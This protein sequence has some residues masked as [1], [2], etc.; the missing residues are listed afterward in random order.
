VAITVYVD[1]SAKVEQW[2]RDSAVAAAN[3]DL[4]RILFISSRIKQQARQLSKTTYGPTAV[5]YRLMVVLIYLAVRESLAM[6]DYVVIDKD[7]AGEKIEGTIKNL[8]LDLIR[9]D[10]PSATAG[11]IR[12]ENVKGSRADR[13]AKQ[14]YDGKV[15]PDHSL[16]YEEVAKLL[17]K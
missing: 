9:L 10:K 8:L 17:R 3:D 1:L 6:V 11:M 4:S 15:R 14:A 2:T 5:T 7:Y 13:L 12:F 16:K